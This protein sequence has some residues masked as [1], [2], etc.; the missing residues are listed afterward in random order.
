MVRCAC[1]AAF[2]PEALAV[3]V[4]PCGYR[5]TAWT[6]CQALHSATKVDLAPCRCSQVDW[7]RAWPALNAVSYPERGPCLDSA[8]HVVDSRGDTTRA[9]TGTTGESNNW[10]NEIH[11]TPAGYSLPARKWRPLLDTIT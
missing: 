4:E 1:A 10:E 6:A 9:V 3:W 5:A 7:R 8:V 2:E 11:P